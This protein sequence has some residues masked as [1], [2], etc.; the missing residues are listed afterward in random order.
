MKLLKWCPS[1]I[2]RFMGNAIQLEAAHKY[3]TV[4]RE[5]LDKLNV[6]V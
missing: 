1:S 3:A 6:Q 2:R 4:D 5:E